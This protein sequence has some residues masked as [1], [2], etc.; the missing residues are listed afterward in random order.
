MDCRSS[1]LV[2]KE[3]TVSTSL[4]GRC[5][6]ES[7]R[8]YAALRHKRCSTRVPRCGWLVFGLA[9]ASILFGGT[10]PLASEP[11]DE[12]VSR[13]LGN[14]LFAA[15]PEVQLTEEIYGDAIAA[16]G[17]RERASRGLSIGLGQNLT[18]AMVPFGLLAR[19]RCQP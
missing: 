10:Q 4:R 14:D 8:H 17:Y 13:Q 7:L 9:L 6:N 1:H 19:V 11:G 12:M 2:L 15:G 3:I 5:E 16:G 18:E